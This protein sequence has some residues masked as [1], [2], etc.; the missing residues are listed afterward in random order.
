[1][2]PEVP[3]ELLEHAADWDALHRWERSELGKKLRR[4]G[5]TY[6]EIRELIPV[7]KSTLSN[8]CH[9]ITLTTE[10]IEAIRARGYSHAGVPRD[11]QRKRR[12]EVD[13][14]RKSARLSANHL[15][16]DAL[17]VAGVAMY[18]AEGSKSRNDLAISNTDPFVLTLF[19]NWVRTY[20]DKNAEFRL[21][22]H[23]HEG[24]DDEE[25]R[26][27][28]REVLALPTAGFTK[29]FVKPPGTG[30]RKNRLPHGVCRIRVCRSADHWQRTMEWIQYMRDHIA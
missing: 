28:W 9:E 26:T 16:S 18:W 23:L 15:A 5:L 6:G 30:H 12:E 4:L 3:Q 11:T 14:I 1:M 20:L 21:S 22:L 2:K 13:L 25:A 29:T 24:N 27:Y 19:V 17:F 7:P 10:Q 8:W